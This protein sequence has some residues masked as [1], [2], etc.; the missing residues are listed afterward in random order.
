LATSFEPCAK[1]IAAPVNTI[2]GMNNRST[3][4]YWEALSA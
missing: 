1:A 4:A 3:L 2:C